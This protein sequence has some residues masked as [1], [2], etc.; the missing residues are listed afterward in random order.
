MANGTQTVDYDALA[1]QAGAISSQSVP[2]S[3]GVDYAALAKQAG[4]V[5]S[6]TQPQPDSFWR[7]QYDGT[8]GDRLQKLVGKLSDWA[9]QKA[10]QKGTEDQARVAQGGKANSFAAEAFSPRA[11]YDL[12][13]HT[14][15]LASSFIEPKNLALTGGVIAANTNPFTGIPVDAALVAHGG[16]GMYKNAPAALQGNPDAAERFF[17]SGAEASGGTAGTAGQVR[18]FRAPMSAPAAAGEASTPG[19]PEQAAATGAPPAEQGPSVSV[20]AR[21]AA[22]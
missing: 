18:A 11:G 5:D 1:K 16:Y 19:T 9:Q 10:N 14:A 7:R 8:V 6:Q 13:A 3:G 21:G 20:Q 15:G 4:A 22:P 12:L 2:Q 17:L